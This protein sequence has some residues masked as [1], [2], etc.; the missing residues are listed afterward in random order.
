MSRPV[1]TREERQ[2]ISQHCATVI[3]NFECAGRAIDE[4]RE[5]TLLSLDTAAS[6]LGTLVFK[7]KKSGERRN[8]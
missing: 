2:L 6:A 4:D 5:R 8:G 7:L 3:D 1:F